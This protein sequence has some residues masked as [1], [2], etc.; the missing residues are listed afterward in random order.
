[1]ALLYLNGMFR[2]E[3][4][5]AEANLMDMSR[6]TLMFAF[7]LTALLVLHLG[8]TGV[9]VAQLL[10][11]ALVA[12]MG[13]RWFGGVRP[14][15][16][17]RWDV[18]RRLVAFGI[19]IYSFSILLYLNYRIDLFLVRSKLDLYQTGLYSTAVALAEIL[20]MVPA[21]L[22]A[23]L[24]PS[25]A[26]ASGNDRDS[27]TMAVC[28]T[29]FWLMMILCVM[30]GLGRNLALGLFFGP[31]FVGAGHALLALLPGILAM[32]L[33]QVLGSALSGRGRPLPVTLGAGVGFVANVALNLVWIPQY[34]IVGAALASSVSYTLVAVMVMVAY[35]RITGSRLSEVLLLKREDLQRCMGAFLRFK[36]VVIR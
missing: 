5:I 31:R 13:F 25:V 1:M 7:I 28:R 6:A 12:L 23:V 14:V 30:L 17:F 19:Q 29:S 33:Q 18:L 27:L 26:S 34:G 20:W 4:K 21:S 35:L 15:P 11:E 8:V 3:M 22:S 16:L 32:S 24:F 2:G 36:Q 9:I 10:A